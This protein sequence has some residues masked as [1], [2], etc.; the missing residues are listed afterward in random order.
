LTL[1]NES[2][3]K[4]A[5]VL[6]AVAV[7]SAAFAGLVSAGSEGPGAAPN[8]APSTLRIG[9]LQEPDSLN[10][11]IGVLSES[12][13]IWAHVY[14]LLVAI[15]PDLQPYPSLAYDWE[16]DAA[17]LNWTF[18]LLDN[19]TWH[20]GVPFTA[21]DVNFTFRYIAPQSPGNPIGCDQ[22]LL[23]G[24]LGGVDIDNITVINST[25]IRI[26][27]LEPKANILSMFIQIL[28]QHIWDTGRCNQAGNKN[29][30]PIGTGMYKFTSWVR[31]NYIQLDLNTDY[32]RLTPG[33]DY[34]DTI[35]ISFYRDSTSLYNAFLAGDIQATDALSS[36]EFLLMPSSVAGGTNNVVKFTVDS[37]SL[38]EVGMCVA[39]DQLIADNRASGGRNWLLTNLTVRQALQIAVNRTALVENVLNGLGR[40][41][42]TL[43]PPATPFW[44]YSPVGAEGYD[45][46]PGRARA[47]LDDPAGDG[48]TLK[49]GQTVP[50]NS[51]ENLDPGA[52]NNQDAFIDTSVPS[53]G[54]RDVVDATRVIAG[55][56]WGTSAPNSNELRF[57]LSL[58]NYDT[59]G[60]DAADLE[61]AWWA[62]V[63][64][65]VTKSI[66]TES[67]MITITY[68][69]SVD[70]YDWGWGGDV[71]PDFLLSVMTTNQILY[72]QDAWYS[73]PQYD[74]WYLDQQVEVNAT[75]RQAIIH[76][77]QRKLYH[78]A[79]Y[80]ITWY[81]YTLT[82]VRSD[83]F[84]GWGDWNAYPGLG[85]TGY[86]NDLV[87]LTL[88]PS[89]GPITNQCPTRPIIE[90]TSPITALVNASVTFTGNATDPEDDPLTW[91]WAWDDG[92][93]TQVDTPAG[94]T[95]SIEAYR[96]PA[97]GS[98]NVTLTVDDH[99][100]GT[101]VTSDPFRVN[102]VSAPA[103]GWINGTVRDAGTSNP[104]PGA[105]VT[106][107]SGTDT[108]GTTTD[109]AG[110]YNLSVPE[111]AFTVRAVQALYS[112]ATQAGVTVTANATTTVNFDLSPAR[113]WITGVVT[114]SLGG[115]IVGAT[116]RATGGGREYPGQTIAGGVY[117][118]TV[119]PGTYTVE[120]SAPGFFAKNSTGIAVADGQAITLNFVLEPTSPP[121]W[122]LLTIGLIGL[123]VVLVIAAMAA[124]LVMKRRKKAEEIAPTVP[125]P[126][127]K[128]P[129]GP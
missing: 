58:L 32:W 75:R 26:P 88:L 91:T 19:A 101:I 22:T 76:D 59:E 108:F 65:A 31:G 126:P 127:P 119:A 124:F 113:G 129:S 2:V 6:M 73:D 68:D 84:T 35:I 25:A 100:C 81:P 18:D 77:M 67:R 128:P 54:V 14:E 45:Y 80:L 94:T 55:D 29:I 111:G 79:P 122:D 50:G 5:S 72:W 23:Q 47:L 99:Q 39:S 90:G 63:G 10:P 9:A 48:Y 96:W 106:A 107:T 15:G 121:G 61:I 53:D 120:A 66:V 42:E 85:L 57:T 21:E 13:V 16:V 8:Q 97:V 64:I 4:Y 109:L 51:G 118:V 112:P 103:V 87:M 93:T 46:D 38:S 105:S 116:V 30:P 71:D 56:Q 17:G 86:G 36:A 125:P 104:I 114:S 102:V 44:H 78:D 7:L 60:Q 24:Y 49:A 123:G 62:D 1:R 69:C 28:P 117:N 40:P 98:Y 43:I 74:Q 37:I 41:G 3:W 92:N 11:F 34:V 20:D 12:Y 82:V 83:L 95:Q 115:P 27:T 33:R 70:L 89:S 52:A 110:A